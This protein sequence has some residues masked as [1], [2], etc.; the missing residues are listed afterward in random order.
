MENNNSDLDLV[1]LGIDFINNC[2]LNCDYDFSENGCWSLY[3][4]SLVDG[5]FYVGITLYP[6]ERIFNHFIGNGANFTKK[7][8]VVGLV[9]LKNLNIEDRKTC[10][11]METEKAKEYRNKYGS[12]K[13]VGGKFLALKPTLG[14]CNA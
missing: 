12:D 7:N 11:K 14:V 2:K 10:Y 4:L 5:F 9:E 8:R 6:Q 1:K 3:V 13:V